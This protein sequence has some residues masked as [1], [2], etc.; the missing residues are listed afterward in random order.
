MKL[1]FKNDNYKIEKGIE[2][3]LY[4]T[5]PRE[6]LSIFPQKSFFESLTSQML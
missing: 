6:T 1:G 5:K 2:E 3:M 4:K